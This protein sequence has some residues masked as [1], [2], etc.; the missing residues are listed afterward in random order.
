MSVTAINQ[1]QAMTEGIQ[2]MN[3][4]LKNIVTT[5]MDLQERMLKVNVAET[6]SGITGI[7]NNL[8]VEA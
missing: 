2:R 4:M 3:D 7:G 5:G 6:V 8:D 1:Q